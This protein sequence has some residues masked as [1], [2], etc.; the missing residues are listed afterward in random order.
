MQA[1]GVALDL[2]RVHS[3]A[4]GRIDSGHPHCEVDGVLGCG[5]GVRDG[6]CDCDDSAHGIG[7]VNGVLVGANDTFDSTPALMGST[8]NNWLGRSQWVQD[9]HFMQGTYDEF[10]IYDVAL[11]DADL[12][13]LEAAGPDALAP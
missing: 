8:T 4:V 10:R 2:N 5:G 7:G 1:D 6:Q 9:T 3:P 13:A 12:A 11:S